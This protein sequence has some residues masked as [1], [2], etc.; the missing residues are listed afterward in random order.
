MSFPAKS[1]TPKTYADYA[2]LPE[3]A[4]YQLIGGMFVKSPS[5]TVNHQRIIKRIAQTLI[6]LEEKGLGEL[7]HA[8]IDVYLSDTE[9]YQ[10]DIIFIT[11]ERLF[12]IGEKKIEGA[13]DMVIEVLSP[14]TAYYDLGHK[15]KTYQKS[16]VREYWVVDPMEKSIELY[17]NA[18]KVFH[19]SSKA[20]KRG[21]VQSML[22][23]SLHVCAESI[24]F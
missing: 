2:K 4:P 13:P 3:G 24:F 5:P 16:G 14:R 18:G 23:P 15:M 8:P 10:P 17:E 7:F 22:F 21:E 11:V 9:T 19:L 12:I 1:E 6:P 20:E